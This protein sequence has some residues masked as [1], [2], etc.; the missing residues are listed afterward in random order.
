MPSLS[1]LPDTVSQFLHQKVALAAK[2]SSEITATS[3]PQAS[4]SSPGNRFS[5]F[6]ELDDARAY[7]PG[8]LFVAKLH[9][10]PEID[11]RHIEGIEVEIKNWT[12]TF[13][14]KT[15]GNTTTNTFEKD[16]HYS[17]KGFLSAERWAGP[18]NVSARA[19]NGLYIVKC[20]GP[21]NTWLVST[22]LP[23]TVQFKTGWRK[24]MET[25]LIPPTFQDVTRDRT[26]NT[27]YW[28]IKL[29]VKRTG[30]LLR[31]YRIWRPFIVLPFSSNPAPTF[32]LPMLVISSNGIPPTP[33]LIK[34][35]LPPSWKT[36]SADSRIKTAL[37]FSKG[38]LT[39]HLFLP[40]MENVGPGQIPI[41][42]HV[43]VSAKKASDLLPSGSVRLPDLPLT[44]STFES[45]GK[46]KAK[47]DAA[48]DYH[49]FFDIRR[50][51]RSRADGG[52]HS[53]EH[54]ILA[55]VRWNTP[56]FL[57]SDSRAGQNVHQ[58]YAWTDPMPTQEAGLIAQTDLPF[59]R[60]ALLT[61]H[62][63]VEVPPPIDMH[64]LRVKYKL[65]FHWSQPGLGNSISAEV[66]RL[67]AN[68]G[69]NQAELKQM[70]ERLL[71]VDMRPEVGQAWRDLDRRV[72]GPRWAALRQIMPVYLESARWSY[73]D[74]PS[75][76]HAHADGDDS[77]DFDLVPH[78]DSKVAIHGQSQAPADDLPS[79]DDT[80][81]STSG[82]ARDNK[83]YLGCTIRPLP[84]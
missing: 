53:E 5:V 59:T 72:L 19:E 65:N 47:E 26:N 22:R 38:T 20:E 63:M 24:Y 67:V 15:N 23:S 6:I 46:G 50:R 83:Q 32:S 10:P 48:Q 33:Q 13:G 1:Q 74:E 8:Q 69:V 71:E 81:P 36:F 78:F 42:L 18:G 11:A 64:N 61:G 76:A 27:V 84:P 54:L 21:P 79:Y 41:Y 51:V 28:A 68:K 56:A 7:F 3:P 4:F 34:S 66:G 14:R 52:S 77:D 73:D 16:L 35:A 39:I 57:S 45:R 82:P 44:S 43:A 40:D 2:S 37:I 49:P 31:D 75:A 80:N 17:V 30:A 29:T 55:H 60:S 12:H 25:A 9:L 70:G 62:L 58:G